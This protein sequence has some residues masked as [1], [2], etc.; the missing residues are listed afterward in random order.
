MKYI[1]AFNLYGM[2]HHIISLK[3]EIDRN[4]KAV[5]INANLKKMWIK[6]WKSEYNWTESE[7]WNENST[8]KTDYTTPI[9][10]IEHFVMHPWDLYAQ[11]RV[12][13]WERNVLEFI[14]RI[15]YLKSILSHIFFFSYNLC[16]EHFFQINGFLKNA[17]KFAHKTFTLWKITRL[18]RMNLTQFFKW[19]HFYWYSQTPSANGF[20]LTM[21]ALATICHQSWRRSCWPHFID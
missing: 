2:K 15:E 14:V 4:W 21:N 19:F 8:S 3:C 13:V 1:Y 16:S 18:I 5:V 12:Y 20:V 17:E 11:T 7:T 6:R 9:I 10:V